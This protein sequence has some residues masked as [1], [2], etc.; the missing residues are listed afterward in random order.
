MTLGLTVV[1]S[2]IF[3][4]NSVYEFV[5]TGPPQLESVSVAG[6]FNNWNKDADPMQRD[7][8]TW[9]LKKEIPFG[10]YQYK[11]VLNGENWI[12]DP[13][14]PNTL[15]D[16][17]GNTNSVLVW[18]PAEYNQP[19]VKGDGIIAQTLISHEQKSPQISYDRGQLRLRVKVRPGDVESITAVING[20]KKEL[21]R[22]S[23]SELTE[24][25]TVQFA[26]NRQEDV[27][28]HFLIQ[29]GQTT[30]ALSQSGITT[31]DQAKPYVLNHQTFQPIQVPSWV[32]RSVFYHIFPDRFE[33]GNKS[34]D[35]K[36][37]TPWD[38]TPEYFN[39]FGGDI[40]GVQ[41]R[42]PY[43]QDLGVNAVYF[44]P[45]FASP[46]NHRY[47]T[48]DYKKVDPRFGTNEEFKNLV[49][50]MKGEG[51]K[52]VLDGVF[53]HT[54]TDFPA[55]QDILTNQKDSDH[56]DWFYVKNFPVEVRQDPPYEAWFGFESMPKVNVLN[57]EVKDYF[58][59]VWDFWEGYGIDGWRLDV[60]NEV[61]PEFWRYFRQHLKSIDQNRWIVGENWTDS[62]FWLQGDQ[63]DSAMNYPFRSAV[64]D[65]IA[66]EKDSASHFLDR[67]FEVYGYYSP[68][69][70]RNM[71]N[72][73]G[74]HD[75]PRFLHECQEDKAKAHLGA[76]LLMTWVG[77][78]TV[79]YGD[80]LGMTGGKD[81]ANRLGMQWEL[82]TDSNPTLDLY[83]KL[84][85]ARLNSEALMVGDPV[86]VLTDDT[87]DLVAFGRTYKNDSALVIINRS[88][89]PVDFDQTLSGQLAQNLAG[90]KLTD[91]V[92][93]KSVTL[94]RSAR[95]H[96]SVPPRSGAVLLPQPPQGKINLQ[97]INSNGE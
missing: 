9:R 80:E 71:L 44:N 76:I 43:L 85:K 95:L 54:A 65:Y 23:A 51:M 60:A 16:G 6:S 40:A 93:G 30:L 22:L 25:Q 18:N 33:N 58:A 89:K 41:K 1:A 79:Y 21:S 49:T 31:P 96:W 91:A 63:W 83:E 64:L 46:A 34:N 28:Y 45:V 62:S 68:Q 37:V 8:N 77:A 10:T 67:L 27:T 74:S 88:T 48:T 5:Y 36:D 61:D 26:W 50:K 87:K 13:A 75:T 19:A 38:G 12:T 97:A 17:N 86:R 73:L 2:S 84:I 52:V 78:P 90:K 20:T 70:S 3:F 66:Y 94:D 15:N 92:S 32:E 35:P 7:G 47:E 69:V 56:L 39:F 59:D 24:T 82:A 14:N 53:N 42:L 4:S 72:A 29:D 55:F 81:P 57:P 11:F